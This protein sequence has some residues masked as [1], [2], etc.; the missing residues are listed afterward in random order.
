MLRNPLPRSRPRR[1]P[2]AT[3]PATRTRTFPPT[4]FHRPARSLPRLPARISHAPFPSSV[5][6][7]WCWPL[8]HRQRRRASCPAPPTPSGLHAPFYSTLPSLPLRCTS[9]A[10]LRQ[11]PHMIYLIRLPRSVLP[12]SRQIFLKPSETYSTKSVLHFCLSHSAVRLELCSVY[13]FQSSAFFSSFPVLLH[14]L[15]AAL[16]D[17]SLYAS[18]PENATSTA[19]LR[20]RLRR[21]AAPP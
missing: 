14:A 8:G 16:S 11:C 15:S 3:S 2:A 20:H 9:P 6:A 21:N 5:R 12:G 19:P 1:N 17:G 4:R 10:A 18:S 7:V 13:Q